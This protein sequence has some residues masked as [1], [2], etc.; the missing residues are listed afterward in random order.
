MLP[1]LLAAAVVVVEYQPVNI[2]KLVVQPG[3]R[4]RER[5]GNIGVRRRTTICRAKALKNCV[6]AND[7]ITVECKPRRLIGRLPVVRTGDRSVL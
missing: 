4:I 5:V 3:E 1:E 6:E 2:V 7:G